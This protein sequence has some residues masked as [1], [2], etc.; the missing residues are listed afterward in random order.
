MVMLKCQNFRKPHRA[1]AK[2]GAL[3]VP[4]FSLGCLIPH[5]P[6][7]CVT[8]SVL[9]ELVW[10]A[11]KRNSA[12]PLGTF[13]WDKDNDPYYLTSWTVSSLTGWL[14][15]N[16]NNSPRL[17]VQPWKGSEVATGGPNYP[18]RANDPGNDINSCGNNGQSLNQAFTTAAYVPFPPP[19]PPPPPHSTLGSFKRGNWVGLTTPRKGNSMFNSQQILKQP[20]TYPNAEPLEKSFTELL[21][22]ELDFGDDDNRKVPIHTFSNNPSL[23]NQEW[24]DNASCSLD[25]R[26]NNALHI[27]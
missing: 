20:L 13:A 22:E 7:F 9:A 17:P 3:Y 10:T 16:P 21:S 5:Q 24:P 11:L 27:H 18:A 1:S 25:R 14:N 12:L 6:V 23:L 8:G 2:I 15:N 19:P 4:R 26:K